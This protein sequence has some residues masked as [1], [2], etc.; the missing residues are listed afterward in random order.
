MAN[1]IRMPGPASLAATRPVITKIPAP[2]MAPMP[3]EVRPIGP[4]A[5]RRRLS[6]SASALR[7]SS[8][9]VANSC[10]KNNMNVLVVQRTV[11]F[12]PHTPRESG[13]TSAG[14][15]LHDQRHWPIVDQLHLHHR[16]ELPRG[17]RH[18]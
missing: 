9:L 15:R 1:E 6:P 16:P 4:R 3:S 13:A 7:V 12:V 17:G 2:M 5:R 10:R 14:R 18:P 8:D 11:G